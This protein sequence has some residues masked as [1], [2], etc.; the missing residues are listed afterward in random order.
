M[1]LRMAHL[2]P[3]AF[4][5]EQQTSFTKT[6]IDFGIA[7]KKESDTSFVRLPKVFEF[8]IYDVLL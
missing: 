6:K 5:Q 3:R 4:P 2:T 7:L 1:P 8:R